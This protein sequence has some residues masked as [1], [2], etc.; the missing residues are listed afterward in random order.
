M[1]GQSPAHGLS[2]PLRLRLSA[3]LLTPPHPDG[4]PQHACTLVL[5]VSFSDVPRVQPAEQ[6]EVEALAPG[7][8]R[9][10]VRYGFKDHP[11]VPAVIARLPAMGLSVDPS[12]VSYFLSRSIVVPRAGSAWLFAPSMRDMALWRKLLFAVA[13]HNSASTATYFGLPGNA[14]IELGVQACI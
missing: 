14:V 10:V 9:V 2:P 13:Y 11:D 8:W 4:G 6:I 5:W 1:R 3:P 7:F 12:A